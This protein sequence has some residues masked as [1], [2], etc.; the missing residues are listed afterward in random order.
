[1]LGGMESF[2]QG[3]YDRTPIGDALPV[4]LD[5]RQP[6]LTEMKYQ[7]DLTRE[8][9]IQPW[10]RI[11]STREKEEERLDAMPGFLTL[12]ISQSIKP[13]ASVLA[14]VTAQDE[15]I[16]PAL[17]VQRFGKGRTAALMI[18]DL[19]RWKMNTP[20][21][22]D[23]LDKSW[24]QTL[25]WLVSDVP[26]RVQI[27]VESPRDATD[28]NAA[29]GI[30]VYD[31]EYKPQLNADVSLTVTSPSGQ[32]IQLTTEQDTQR[33]GRYNT[34]FV[35]RESGAYRVTAEVKT[36]EG[37]LIEKRESGWVSEPAAGEFLTLVPNRA[38]L[39]DLA[40][41]TGG[42]VIAMEDL[43]AFADSFE[44]RKVPIEE[45]QTRPWWHRWSI[46]VVA[47]CLLVVEWGYRRLAGLA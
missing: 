41:R 8:G 27:D 9:W 30:Q 26:R 22:N 39:V 43:D 7:L 21:K 47:I 14:N 37:N 12:N 10:I 13:G 42:Q 35:S 46:F 18:G 6:V 5:V 2:A 23:D 29:I 1:M 40:A 24:R 4:Y 17:V 36:P 20:D 32:E 28:S 45:I 31:E 15:K 34:T 38:A 19:W 33:A 16:Y 25:R 3:G 44:N 11:E